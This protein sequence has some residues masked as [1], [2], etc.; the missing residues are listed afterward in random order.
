MYVPNL[1]INLGNLKKLAKTDCDTDSDFKTSLNKTCQ[2]HCIFKT[3]LST[4]SVHLNIFYLS[5][6]GII[7]Y[8]SEL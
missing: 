3:S 4:K 6:H 8:R 2:N 7:V 5:L 1:F